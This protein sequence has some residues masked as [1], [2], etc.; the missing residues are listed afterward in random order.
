MLAHYE[1]APKQVTITFDVS[2]Q[3]PFAVQVVEALEYL[4]QHGGYVWLTDV[5]SLHLQG[6][7]NNYDLDN[8]R[9]S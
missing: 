3:F 9:K 2:V 6:E 5:T 4:P 1:L 8:Y 7:Y